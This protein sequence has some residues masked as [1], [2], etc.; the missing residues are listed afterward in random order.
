MIYYIHGYLS[1]IKSKKGRLLKEKLKVVPIKYR[2]CDPVD[3]EISECLKII[4][5]KIKYDRKAIL[6]GSSFGGY[7]SARVAKMSKNV[8]KLILLNPSII[9]PDVD[10]DKINNMPMRILEEMKEKNLFECKLKSKI[11]IVIGS[12]DKVVPNSWSVEFAKK[13]EANILF[14]DDDHSFSKNLNNIPK[15]INQIINQKN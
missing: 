10:I 4:Y 12:K 11:F 6:I 3:L 7:L 9:P 1:S 8:N 2:D 14:L 5:D 15:I 13:Q